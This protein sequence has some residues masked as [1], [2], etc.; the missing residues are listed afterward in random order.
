V[1]ELALL[2]IVFATSCLA[3]IIGMGGGVLLLMLMPGLVPIAAILPLHALTQMASNA[4]RAAFGWRA[5]DLSL[6]PAFT[7]GALAGGWLGSEVYQLLDERWLPAYIGVFI[8][9]FTWLPLPLVRGGG[10]L[11]LAILGFVQTG[12]GMLAGATGPLGAAVLVRR[13]TERDW[14]VVNTAVYM[15]LNHTLR[16]LA[17]F[18][19]GFSYAP[20]WPLVTGMVIAGIAGSWVGTRLRHLV[21]QRDFHKWFRLLVSV[22]A[23]RMIALAV[24]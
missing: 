7:V 20:W 18:A 3:A 4:S 2:P 24:L 10:Q 19:I 12:L 11:A 13:N 5:I 23:V 21:P 16:V 1:T 22:L 17:Y 9:V 14:L 8:L 6:V 15:T